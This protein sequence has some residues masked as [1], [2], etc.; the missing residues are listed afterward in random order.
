MKIGDSVQLRD[1]NGVVGKEVYTVSRIGED[2]GIFVKGSWTEYP[3][4]KVVPFVPSAEV[5]STEDAVAEAIRA[6]STL[7]VHGETLAKSVSAALAQAQSAQALLKTSSAA[8]MAGTT[9]SQ[10]VQQFDAHIAS[11]EV[12]I[13]AFNL[14]TGK[15]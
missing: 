3:A 8:T 10:A 6:T 12:A 5:Q 2:G 14:A 15:N 11:L 9:V 4:D 1:E 7:L 13:K